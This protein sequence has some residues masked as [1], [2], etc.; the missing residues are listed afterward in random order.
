MLSKTFSHNLSRGTV[1]DMFERPEIVW[2]FVE[3][4]TER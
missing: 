2:S 1:K 3:V 4:L